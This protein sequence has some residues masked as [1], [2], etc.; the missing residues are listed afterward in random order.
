MI[1]THSHV[2][3]KE[4]DD[5]REEM[6][7]RAKEAGVSQ[8]LLPNIDEESISIL[9]QLVDTHPDFFKPMMGLHP[10]SVNENYEEQ[11]EVILQELDRRD[12]I[13]VGEIGVDLYWDKSTQRIQEEAFIIQCRWALERDLPIVIHSRDSIDEI[14]AIIQKEFPD[15]IRGVF[16]CFTGTIEQARTIEAM[17]MYMGIGGVVT[18]KNSDLRDVLRSVSIDRLILETDAPYL[19]PVPYRGKRNEP[20]YLTQVV[21]E[22]ARVYEISTAEVDRITTE[23]ALQLFNL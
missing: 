12:H 4:F 3:A 23:N 21:D 8:I 19:A 7:G 9:N 11:L 13:A 5:D 18:F 6:I 10:C 17:G 2:Y 1:D 14:I 15:G 22:L 20:S 16:H